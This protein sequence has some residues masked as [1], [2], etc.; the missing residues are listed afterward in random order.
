M[1]IN[2]ILRIGENVKKLR[3]EKGISLTDMAKILGISKTTY[4]NYE[5]DR[6]NMPND[7]IAMVSLVLKEPMEWVL[8]IQTEDPYMN[9]FDYLDESQKERMLVHCYS[10]TP[11][12]AVEYIKSSK[13]KERKHFKMNI[14]DKPNCK[15]YDPIT[16][17]ADDIAQEIYDRPQLKKL[18]D[19]AREASDEDVRVALGVLN[20]L[21]EKEE[22]K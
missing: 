8:G 19:K 14:E 20:R 7:I 13:T 5:A 1:G 3:I 15:P 18:I 21:M 16:S 9:P 12:E 22:G 10:L 6:R 2:E 4:A 11:D 17:E